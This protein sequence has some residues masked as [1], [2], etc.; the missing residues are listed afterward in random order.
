MYQSVGRVQ[1]V[2]QNFQKK[3]SNIKLNYYNEMCAEM[4]AFH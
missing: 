4:N 2:K 3:K 1:H